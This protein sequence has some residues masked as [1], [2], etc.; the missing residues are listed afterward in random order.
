MHAG[1]TL[2]T[3][4]MD[5]STCKQVKLNVTK[6]EFMIVG[7]R[8]KLE[9]VADNH[10]ITLNIERKIIKRVDHAK[11]LGLYIDKKYAH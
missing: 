9:T 10:C 11:S 6:S 7:S 5:Q 2:C 4:F 1:R 8:Q 3:E